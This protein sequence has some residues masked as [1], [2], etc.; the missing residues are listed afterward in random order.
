[1]WGMDCFVSLH[2]AEGFGLTMAETMGMGK[3]V[4]ATD[5]SGNL[6]FMDV[7]NSRLVKNTL[8][9][10][11]PGNP[12]YPTT[13]HWARP[14]IRHAALVMRR[15][16]GNPGLVSRLGSRPAAPSSCAILRLRS[17]W[18]PRPG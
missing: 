7:N 13:A 16:R 4:V 11:P 9:P 14:S 17:A 5:Y 1:M 6:T 18:S 15:L 3:A 2:R 10:I 8:V 12:P